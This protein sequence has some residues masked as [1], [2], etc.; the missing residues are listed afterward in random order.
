MILLTP[1][2]SPF[3]AIF[4]IFWRKPAGFFT[5]AH[6]GTPK[7]TTVLLRY[8]NC[9]QRVSPFFGQVFEV[10]EGWGPL[11][12]FL[13]L[14]VPSEPFPRVNDTPTMIKMIHRAWWTAHLFFL[15][16][17]AVAAGAAYAVSRFVDVGQLWSFA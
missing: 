6:S 9:S 8:I 16:V 15:G 17:P 10:K 13:D 3:F 11:C 2:K 14:P 4:V 12:Q 1:L 7:Y 5:L